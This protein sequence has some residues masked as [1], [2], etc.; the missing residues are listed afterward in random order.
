MEVVTWPRLLEAGLCQPA[1]ALL[2][3]ASGLWA[4]QGPR[5]LDARRR[6]EQNPR[7]TR[8]FSG[9]GKTVLRAGPCCRPCPPEAEP[10]PSWE[11]LGLRV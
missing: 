6:P 10:G 5:V 2:C 4:P 11:A 8:R 3:S 9:A 1:A 7:S